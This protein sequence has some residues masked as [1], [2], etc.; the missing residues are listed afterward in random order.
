MQILHLLYLG[1]EIV[2]NILLSLNGLFY[3]ALRL[4][5]SVGQVIDS[6]FLLFEGVVLKQFVDLVRGHSADLLHVRNVALVG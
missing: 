6:L 4:H 3:H 1:L 5:V 2:G